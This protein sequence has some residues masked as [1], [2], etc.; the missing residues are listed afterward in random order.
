MPKKDVDELFSEWD[1]G[2]D[3]ALGFKELQKILSAARPP[4]PKAQV[5]EAGKSVK[6]ALKMV[7]LM[8][9]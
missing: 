7:S 4:S 1:K 3:G 2:G 8:K 5:Q 6:N 9:K